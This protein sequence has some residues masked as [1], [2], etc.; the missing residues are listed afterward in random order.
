MNKQYALLTLSLF[1]FI[2][3]SLFAQTSGPPSGGGRSSG[4]P[5]QSDEGSNFSLIAE[6]EISRRSNSISVAGRLEPSSRIVHKASVEGYISTVSVEEGDYVQAGDHLFRIDRKDIG[7]TF[8]PVYVDARISG[9]VS[10]IDIQIYSDISAGSPGVTIV[11][12]DNY[13][14]EAVVSDKDAFKITVGQTVTGHNPDGLSISGTLTGRSQEPDY[15]TGLFSLTFQ[16]P[17]KEGFYIGSFILIQLPTDQLRGIFISRDLLVRR[18]GSYYVWV[19][20]TE[21]KFAAR[22]IVT[23]AAFGNEVHIISGLNP[24]EK[25]LTSLTGNETEGMELKR[26]NN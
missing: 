18:Y 23:G 8:K 12:T 15:N 24:G 21:N 3:G 22:E 5:L 2:S 17:E 16:F 7:Q 20:D 6:A 13:T 10:E 19:L 4:R 14:V 26:G 11:A 25:Y 1:L 9:I